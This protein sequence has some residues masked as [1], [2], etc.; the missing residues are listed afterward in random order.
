MEWHGGPLRLVGPPEREDSVM[1]PYRE[2]AKR[3]NQV[4]NNK[5]SR[6]LNLTITVGCGDLCKGG[7]GGGRKGGSKKK[8][9]KG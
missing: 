4:Q 9:E 7:E 6:K 3:S 1:G 8:S 2:G 5:N